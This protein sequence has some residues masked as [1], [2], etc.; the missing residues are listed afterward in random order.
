[1]E[2]LRSRAASFGWSVVAFLSAVSAWA[3][4][5][6]DGAANGRA[7]DGSV[8]ASND[9]SVLPDLGSGSE[10][11]VLLGPISGV[12]YETV[13]HGG[14]TNDDGRFGYEPGEVVTFRIGSVELGSV[15]GAPEV[16]PFDLVPNSRPVARAPRISDALEDDRHSLRQ[17]MNLAVFLYSLDTDDDPSNGVV[18]DSPVA[19]LFEGAELDFTLPMRS[20]GFEYHLPTSSFAD[21]FAFRSRLSRANTD[22]LF[23]VPH[24]ATHYARA[25]QALYALV[26]FDA[27][28]YGPA[29]TAIDQ[30]IDDI[31]DQNWSYDYDAQG[32][33]IRFEKVSRSGRTD[34]ETYGYDR[35][36][37]L[38]ERSLAIN[39]NQP[40]VTRWTYDDSDR[41]T[42]RIETQTSTIEAEYWQYDRDGNLTRYERDEDGD[43]DLNYAEDRVYDERGRILEWRID[44]NTD[45]SP[46]TVVYYTYDD[47]QNTR[48]TERDHDVDGPENNRVEVAVYD[49]RGRLLERRLDDNSSD[50]IVDEVTTLAWDDD[51]NL[52]REERDDLADGTVDFIEVRTFD[53][54]G[55]EVLRETDEDADGVTDATIVWSYDEA[56]R[57]LSFE[58]D[59]DADGSP[60]SRMRLVH[61]ERGNR[62]RF[63]RDQPVGDNLERQELSEYDGDD[64]Q[65]RW[66]RNIVERGLGR[67]SRERTFVGGGWLYRD[68]PFYELRIELH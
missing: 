32:R 51:V 10:L 28:M 65:I 40:I 6:D 46:D 54:D 48:R 29:T 26:A 23:V 67:F 2:V 15:E 50:G 56:G 20:V 27:S 42:S 5:D 57:L 59:S 34:I 14:V 63:E 45:G 11:G 38:L 30:D 7:P 12:A 39:D 44:G 64:N 19:A 41:R 58:R 4:T 21:Q 25:L 53:P 55:N 33:L 47:E 66:E 16:S 9:G 24:G 62:L 35:N 3:C 31:I 68:Q 22:G 37:N 1:M 13:T 36:W 52:V 8:P 43:G 60:E 61:D 17:V 18:I 49:E